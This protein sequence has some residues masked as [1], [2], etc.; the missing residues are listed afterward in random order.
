MCC[1]DQTS[2]YIPSI[3]YIKEALLCDFK[4][5]M[6][7]S[8]EWIHQ[9]FFLD[10]DPADCDL[11]SLII[12]QNIAK[13]RALNFSTISNVVMLLITKINDIISVHPHYYTFYQPLQVT[14][15]WFACINWQNQQL[16][17]QFVGANKSTDFYPVIS[18]YRYYTEL[19]NQQCDTYQHWQIA[20]LPQYGILCG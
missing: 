10:H 18:G 8:Q 6:N 7:H 11:R 3:D 9:F 13:K 15:S 12:K 16:N 4:E 17:W 14:T 5:Q 1:I 20:H 2:L 19:A